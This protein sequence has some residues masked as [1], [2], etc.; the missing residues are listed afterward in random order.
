MQRKCFLILVLYWHIVSIRL[1]R[2]CSRF[3][4]IGRESKQYPYLMVYWIMYSPCRDRCRS[5]QRTHKRFDSNYY[6]FSL[7]WSWTDATENSVNTRPS[8]RI[9]LSQM[10]RAQCL[11]LFP[12]ITDHLFINPCAIQ[13]IKKHLF[14]PMFHELECHFN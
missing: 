5:T 11:T 4:K 8:Y 3:R 7:E 14:K 13:K 9:Y 2:C 12:Y 6:I 10:K 1:L